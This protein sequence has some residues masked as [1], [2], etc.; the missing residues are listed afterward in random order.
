MT[1]F[2][3]YIDK[4]KNWKIEQNDIKEL[5]CW[6][7]VLNY[8]RQIDFKEKV[9]WFFLFVLFSKSNQNLRWNCLLICGKFNADDDACARYYPLFCTVLCIHT[10]EMCVFFGG[11]FHTGRYRRPTP[12]WGGLLSR[13]LPTTIMF[14]WCLLHFFYSFLSLIYLFF[15]D[16]CWQMPAS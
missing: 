7:I 14:L 10:K 16:H 2:F 8:I 11:C 3:L 6:I 4:K 12:N 13:H 1:F 15:N 9:E 5:N